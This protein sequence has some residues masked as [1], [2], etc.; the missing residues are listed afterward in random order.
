MS[1]PETVEPRCEFVQ[2]DGRIWLLAMHW[3]C[4]VEG[5]V[6][7]EILAEYAADDVL[8]RQLGVDARRAFEKCRIISLREKPPPDPFEMIS[9]GKRNKFVKGSL[10]VFVS[11]LT[12][13]RKISIQ[14]A[15][16]PTG[17]G[18]VNYKEKLVSTRLSDLNLGSAI[19]DEFRLIRRREGLRAYEG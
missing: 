8:P 14:G 16:A 1:E 4:R 3:D 15:Y 18:H 5:T 10:A 13:E 6:K 7:G 12:E 19:L 17:Y 11:K 9:K 2:R